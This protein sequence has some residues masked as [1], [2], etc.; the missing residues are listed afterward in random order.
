[1]RDKKMAAINDHVNQIENAELC[2]NIYKEFEING[3]YTL[4]RFLKS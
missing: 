4:E 2:E 3:T 1:M